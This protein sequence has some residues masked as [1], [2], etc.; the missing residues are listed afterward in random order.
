[1]TFR[2]VRLVCDWRQ[3]QLVRD[4]ANLTRLLARKFWETAIIFAEPTNPC[5]L[6]CKVWCIPSCV[7]P[8]FLLSHSELV[9]IVDLTRQDTYSLGEIGHH[10]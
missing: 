5:Q 7:F 1:M 8:P 10:T 9:V 4:R 2:S 6:C 3:T